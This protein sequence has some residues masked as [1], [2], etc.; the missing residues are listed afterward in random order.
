MRGVVGVR[1]WVE[2]RRVWMR[3]D[4]GIRGGEWVGMGM[5]M[6]RCENS[7]VYSR[8]TVIMLLCRYRLADG[9]D[10]GLGNG[11]QDVNVDY[12]GEWRD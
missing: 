12:G 2:G 4:G 9:I 7:G 6:L 1:G 3:V 5:R 8:C 10:G 11:W